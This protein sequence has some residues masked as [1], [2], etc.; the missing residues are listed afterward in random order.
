MHTVKVIA[1]GLLLLAVFVLSGRFF[2]SG[3]SSA[4]QAALWFIGCWLLV[5]AG[6]LLA[7]VIS[8]GYSVQD[9]LPIFLV[10]FAVPSG[11]AL[12]LRKLVFGD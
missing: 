10:V 8:A 11:V 2:G 12:L 7:G 4:A 9:E 5:S 3:A 1:A 6:N